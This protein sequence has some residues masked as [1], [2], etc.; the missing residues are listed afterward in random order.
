MVASWVIA[1]S[2]VH[3][4]PGF[5][6]LARELA[7]GGRPRASVLG[8]DLLHAPSGKWVVLEDNLRVPSGLGYAIANRRTAATALPMLHPWPDLVSP[9]LTPVLWGLR[10]RGVWFECSHCVFPSETRVNSPALSTGAY[11]PVH[12]IVGNSMFIH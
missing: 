9:D 1:A 8:F 3:N 4:C 12:G 7:P 2:V 5:L 10:E 6:P 11:P